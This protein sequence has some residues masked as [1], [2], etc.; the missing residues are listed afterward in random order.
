MLL[1]YQIYKSKENLLKVVEC[2]KKDSVKYTEHAC[3]RAMNNFR[4]QIIYIT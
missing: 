4:K 2:L 1:I 3:I